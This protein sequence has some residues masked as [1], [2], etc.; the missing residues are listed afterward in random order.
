M[1]DMDPIL[2][3]ANFQM[4]ENENRIRT[5]EERVRKREPKGEEMVHLISRCCCA[6]HPVASW[7]PRLPLS[8]SIYLIQIIDERRCT[9]EIESFARQLL[10]LPEADAAGTLPLQHLFASP[11]GNRIS[12]SARRSSS[13]THFYPSTRS[14][15]RL[16][17]ACACPFLVSS[18][19][20]S[21][22]NYQVV[23]N[24]ISFQ[25]LDFFP[26]TSANIDFKS[27]Q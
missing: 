6:R 14:Y 13:F 27:S 2:E 23:R 8:F 20:P 7:W 22:C 1:A 21:G 11:L 16:S 10:P 24:V 3:I 17:E 25:Q 19:T 9:R 4:A 18:L 12:Y 26:L 5:Y 15:T